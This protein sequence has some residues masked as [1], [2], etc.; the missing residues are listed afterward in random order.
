MAKIPQLRTLHEYVCRCSVCESDD[1]PVATCYA[2]STSSAFYYSPKRQPTGAEK[3]HLKQH[4]TYHTSGMVFHACV[5]PVISTW[6]KW[7]SPPH[8]RLAR[9]IRARSIRPSGSL[10]MPPMIKPAYV[11]V[12]W[13]RVRIRRC[14]V[15]CT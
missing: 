10:S 7:N 3:V 8:V 13:S 6:L 4:F 9:P 15:Q 2:G 1:H 11:W 5:S 12:Q 14:L